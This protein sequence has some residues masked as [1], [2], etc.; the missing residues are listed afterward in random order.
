MS[1]RRVLLAVALA[2]AGYGLA[3]LAAWYA[4]EGVRRAAGE[5]VTTLRAASAERETQLRAAL[6]IAVDADAMDAGDA[7]ALLDDPT[8]RAR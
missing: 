3:H 8:G 1:A 4:P 5:F 2:G 6:G 7:A